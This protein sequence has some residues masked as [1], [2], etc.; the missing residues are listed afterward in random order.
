[1]NT[2]VSIVFIILFYGCNSLKYNYHGVYFGKPI[3]NKLE[4][5]KNPQLLQ[6]N[7]NKNI[8]PKSIIFIIADGAGIGHF[9]THYYSNK[10]FSFDEF[11]HIGLQATHPANEDRIVTDSAAGGSALATGE[12]VIRKSVS[13][14]DSLKLKSI[15]YWA[16][17]NAMSTG[18]ISTTKVNHATPAS[19]GANANS[20][21][22]CDDI[23]LQLLKSEIDVIMGGGSKYWND[24]SDVIAEQNGVSVYFDFDSVKVDDK[25]II[26]LFADNYLDLDYKN[27]YPST[28]NMAKLALEK[29][30][31]NENGFFLMVEESQTDWAGHVNNASYVKTEMQSLDDL[32]RFCL[33]YQSV[34]P[35]VL[36]ILTADH[37]TGGIAVYD[38]DED[39]LNIEFMNSHHSANLVPIFASGPGAEAFDALLDNSEIGKLLISFVRE[40]KNE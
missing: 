4:K 16:E 25:R 8:H 31:K 38:E 27:R 40:R 28:K 9:T 12:K 36:V 7:W 6:S 20:R 30:E 1:M 37:E 23:F 14:K 26:G 18:L 35:D 5:N 24:S 33:E 39:N 10:T 15:I 19:F 34:N 29:L 22:S 17:E 11:E 3:T 13:M 32:V 21:Y 2:L